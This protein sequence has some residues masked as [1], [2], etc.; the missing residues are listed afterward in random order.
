MRLNL[1]DSYEFR[2]YVYC[3]DDEC[4]RSYEQK[5]HG[6]L[7]QAFRLRAKLI[8]VI[9]KNTFSEYNFEN[10]LSVLDTEAIFVG[11]TIGYVEEAFKQ[12]REFRNFWGDKATLRMF[13]DGTIPEVADHGL[14]SGSLKCL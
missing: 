7:D 2:V 4:W 3:L 13:R 14:R 8:R 10:G 9:W 1:K 11:I 5:V 12:A 6:V